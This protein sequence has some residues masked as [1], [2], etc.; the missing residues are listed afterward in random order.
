M[1]LFYLDVDE[2][3]PPKKTR[4][5]LNNDFFWFG[6][7]HVG[8]I[9]SL[10]YLNAYIPFALFIDDIHGVLDEFYFYN[11]FFAVMYSFIELLQGKY[12]LFWRGKVKKC[13]AYLGYRRHA[14][15]AHKQH[16]NSGVPKHSREIRKDTCTEK[17]Q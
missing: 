6:P 2:P 8:I 9:D 16:E 5:R 7:R 3:F 4:T 14:H 13:I 17:R 1:S 15:D 10:W 12:F 11:E